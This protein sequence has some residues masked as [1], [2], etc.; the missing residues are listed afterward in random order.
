MCIKDTCSEVSVTVSSKRKEKRR[1]KVTVKRL[2]YRDQMLSY[3]VK[4]VLT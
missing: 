3:N 1:E 4:S 2:T